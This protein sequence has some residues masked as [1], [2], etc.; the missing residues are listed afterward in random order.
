MRAT[1]NSTSTMNIS[2]I[3]PVHARC[4]SATC[5][6]RIS[7]YAN[8][9]RLSCAPWNGFAFRTVF[10]NAV[11]SR[12]AVSP[13]ARATPRITAVMRPDRAVGSTTLHVTR[14]SCDPRARPASR[15]PPGTSRSTSSAVRVTVGSIRIDSASAAANPEKPHPSPMTTTA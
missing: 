1:T 14:H 11:N 12:G 2:T 9:E 4:C 10:P 5:G 6:N 13:M 7:V 8:S 15:S 3:A